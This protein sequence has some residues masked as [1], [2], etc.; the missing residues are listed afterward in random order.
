MLTAFMV[1]QVGV[2]LALIAAL[3]FLL[4][5][6]DARAALAADREARL[7]ALAAE[8][9]AL[10][11]DLVGGLAAAP[12]PGAG[13]CRRAAPPRRGRA[14]PPER[15]LP[16]AADRP[17][18]PAP[19]PPQGFPVPAPAA[20]AALPD[21]EAELIRRLRASRP[22]PSGRR[23]V[24]PAGA[25]PRQKAVDMLAP[26]RPRGLQAAAGRLVAPC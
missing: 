18:A 5:E 14:A 9:C 3:V 2:N 17:P 7:E 4:R 25:S 6:R 10:G 21:G 13:R 12:A 24:R 26:A 23:E 8:F 11:R 16:A 20:A 19:D 22:A 1:V 15:A